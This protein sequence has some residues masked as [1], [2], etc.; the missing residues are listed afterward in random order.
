MDTMGPKGKILVEMYER[1]LKAVGPRGWWPAE[2]PFE[3]IVGAIL[4]QNTSWANVERAID[5]LKGAG[6]L[7]PSGIRDIAED[8]LAEVIKPSGFYRVKARR[9]KGY[10]HFFYEEFEGDMGRMRS[11]DLIPLRER[12][13]RVDGLGPETADS[14][15]LYALEKPIFVVDAYTKRIFS[16]H[17][18]ISERGNYEEVQ[19]MVMR[20]FGREVGRYNEFHALLVF[21]GKHW[22]RRVPRCEGCPL[23]GL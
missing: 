10:V 23:E 17:N 3:V 4:T 9:L 16:R 1:I 14:I 12:L 20:E 18:L 11:Q 2:S 21:L 15:L 19:G 22:C 8:E 6:I 5:N 7:S 13:L